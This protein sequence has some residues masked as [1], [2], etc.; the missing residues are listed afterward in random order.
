MVCCRNL[1]S[2]AWWS[3]LAHS[4]VSQVL[5]TL[6][7]IVGGSTGDWAA[8]LGNMTLQTGRLSG[9]AEAV[10]HYIPYFDLIGKNVSW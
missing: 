3:K 4:P 1:G 10:E 7:F 9:A 2:A 5:F 8:Q 6:I